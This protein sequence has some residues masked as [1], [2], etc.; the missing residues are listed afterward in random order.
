MGLL[1]HP[2]CPRLS[3]FPGHVTSMAEARG[4]WEDWD[5]WSPE[6]LLNRDAWDSSKYWLPL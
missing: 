4:C 3:G 1:T 2:V 6:Q 5:S